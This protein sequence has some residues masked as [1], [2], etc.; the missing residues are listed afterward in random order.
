[1]LFYRLSRSLRQEVLLGLKEGIENRKSLACG[2]QPKITL[3]PLLFI[4]KSLYN[5]LTLELFVNLLRTA[6]WQTKAS[7]LCVLDVCTYI[8]TGKPEVSIMTV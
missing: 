8:V 6:A 3:E 2:K 7:P 1:M 4:K 5:V